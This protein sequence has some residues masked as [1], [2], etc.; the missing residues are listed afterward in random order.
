MLKNHFLLLSVLETVVHLNMFMETVTIF[1]DSLRSGKVKKEQLLY[2][3]E[4]CNILNIFTFTFDHINALLH[5][6]SINVLLNGVVL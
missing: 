1:Y 5:I 2:K 4:I 3:T 6:K